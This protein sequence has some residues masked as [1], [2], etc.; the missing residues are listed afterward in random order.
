MFSWQKL[1]RCFEVKFEKHKI[2]RSF[3]LCKVKSFTAIFDSYLFV[4]LITVSTAIFCFRDASF[5]SFFSPRSGRD[6]LFARCLFS[7][8]F[9]VHSPTSQGHWNSIN[10]WNYIDFSCPIRIGLGSISSIYQNMVRQSSNKRVKFC[11]Y[12]YLNYHYKFLLNENKIVVKFEEF[13]CDDRKPGFCFLL[14]ALSAWT[15]YQH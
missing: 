15:W 4:E 11:K 12:Y 9:D 8:W 5:E 1:I 2:V 10:W 7:V 14:K 13:H 6:I 3:L